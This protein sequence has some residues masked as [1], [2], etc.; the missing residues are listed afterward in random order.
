MAYSILCLFFKLKCEYFQGLHCQDPK[1]PVQPSCTQC[2]K[3]EIGVLERCQRSLAA[4]PLDRGPCTGR[5]TCHT[6]RSCSPLLKFSGIYRCLWETNGCPRRA[7]RMIGAQRKHQLECGVGRR[8]FSR[9]FD[10]LH[11]S[12]RVTKAVHLRRVVGVSR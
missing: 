11:T 5:W 12:S 6:V 4:S 1:P 8:K 2:H 3:E 10:A 9:H 7:G